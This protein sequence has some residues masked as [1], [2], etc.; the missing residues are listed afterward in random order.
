LGI[1][2][3]DFDT[4]SQIRII[5]FAFVK[6]LRKKCKYNEAVHKRFMNFKKAND[7]VRNV[8]LCKILIAFGDPTKLVMLIKMC[9]NK[10]YSRDRV[11]N[12]L[13]LTVLEV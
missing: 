2:N 11:D 5:N 12:C 3:V 9:L 10:T 7:S 1:I 6:Y 8:V 13:K 4:R